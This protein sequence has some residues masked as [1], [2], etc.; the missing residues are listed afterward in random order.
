MYQC[1]VSVNQF[2]M[3]IISM[4]IIMV[5]THIF[6]FFVEVGEKKD[7]VVYTNSAFFRY[8]QLLYFFTGNIWIPNSIGNTLNLR[9]VRITNF[10][11]HV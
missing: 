1:H 6:K 9:E 7:L 8:R 5:Y 2:D 10:F 4:E 3:K 11:F